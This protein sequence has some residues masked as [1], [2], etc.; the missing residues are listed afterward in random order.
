M[1]L[2]KIVENRREEVARQREILP[3]G[4]LRQMLADS[5]PTRDFEGAIRNREC[6]VIAEVKRSSPSKGRIREDFDPVGIAGIYKDNGASAISILTEQKHFEGSA[7]YVPQISS[8]VGLPLLRKDFIID[9]YQVSE[10]RVLGADALLLIARILGAGELRDFIGLASELGLAALVEVHD[11]DDVE[12]AVGS[13]ARIVGINN[14]D[15]ATFRTDLAVSIGLARRIPKGVTVVS[16]SG[17]NSRGDIERL[18]GGGIHAFLI[19]ESLMREQDIGKKLRELLGS[20]RDKG[21]GSR[22]SPK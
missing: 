22:G 21:K 17:I 20:D 7:A 12:K 11:E 3:I 15:L 13:G 5:P 4:E 9:P 8:V 6:A 10:T 18:M 16:E 1:I 2:Q 19:G 14:R